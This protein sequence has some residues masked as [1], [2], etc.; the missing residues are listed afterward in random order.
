[1]S[2][3]LLSAEK[4]GA[5][6][7]F[8]SKKTLE[9][10]G[11]TV[12]DGFQLKP[13]Y[14]LTQVRAI[15][16]R[17]NQNYDGWPSDELKKSY[18][19]F[20]GKPCFVNHENHDPT[21][22]RGV[23]VA[24]RY[25][26]SGMDKYIET[27]MEIDAGR[28]PKL[29]H[30][31]K[32]GGLDSV[33]MGAEAGF[34]IC[35]YCHNKATDLHDMCSHVRNHKGKTLSR[36]D[37]KT[38]K[39][40][41]V[42][43]FESCHKISFFEL[44][45]VF[46]PADE[47]AVASKVVVAGKQAVANGASE[48]WGLHHSQDGLIDT[49]RTRA[50]AEAKLQEIADAHERGEAVDNPNFISIVPPSTNKMR[51][52]VEKGWDPES[53]PF[54]PRI[55]GASVHKHAGECPPGM[56]CSRTIPGLE[57]ITKDSPNNP[58]NQVSYDPASLGQPGGGGGA[59]SGYQGNGKS[60]R[61]GLNPG[62]QSFYDQ[63]AKEFPGAS[64]GGYNPVVDQPW[65]EHGTG[66]AFDFMTS[67]INQGNA[68]K[69]RALANGAKHVIWQQK[70]W[71]PG[72]G[73]EAMENRGSPTEN[74]YDH[75]HFNIPTVAK[76]VTP[77]PAP[78]T[79]AQPKA[80]APTTR[81]AGKYTKDD[82]AIADGKKPWERETPKRA[83]VDE[84]AA[85]LKEIEAMVR[86]SAPAK[87]RR[88]NLTDEYLDYMYGE[89][90]GTDYDV[91]KHPMDIMYDEADH[92]RGRSGPRSGPSGPGVPALHHA[93]GRVPRE[94][95]GLVSSWLPL[96]GA[97]TPD[98]R[99]PVFAHYYIPAADN[100]RA[101]LRHHIN[102]PNDP[103][104]DPS[105]PSLPRDEASRLAE[106]P[107][108]W[109]IEQTD[110]VTGKPRV[111]GYTN[112]LHLHNASF[113]IS[114]SGQKLTQTTGKK[115][116]HAGVSGFMIPQPDEPLEYSNVEY[117][118]YAH[119]DFVH[120]ENQQP[121]GD[122]DEWSQRRG[123]RSPST[124]AG[125]RSNGLADHVHLSPDMSMYA[126]RAD[127]FGLE[128]P[129]VV[130]PVHP[131]VNA[132][133][134]DTVIP[135]I[136]P[137]QQ[138]PEVAARTR[139]VMEKRRMLD[140]AK[141]RSVVGMRKIAR[142][143]ALK[144]AYGEVEAPVR[145]DTLREEGSAPEDDN[146][147]DQRYVDPA[148]NDFANIIS[149][150]EELQT[151]DLSEAG[152]ID[153]EQQQDSGQSG[154]PGPAEGGPAP[155][156]QGN[157]ITLKIPVPAQAPQVP[158]QAGPPVAA[159]PQP[160][161][162]PQA[163]AG[164]PPGPQQPPITASLLNYFD[165]YYGRRVA[166]WLDAIEAGRALNPAE[167]ADYRRQTEKFSTLENAGRVSTTDRY[168]R[169]GTANMA[170]TSIANRN[171]V[172][173]AGRR[174]HFAEGPLVDGGDRSRNDQ[175]E[176]EKA[177]ISQTPPEVPVDFPT[178]DAPNISN[179]EHNLVARVQ[180]G[181]AQLLRDAQALA[182]LQR[183]RAFDEAGGPT[184]EVVDPT[185]Q[186]GP[187]G[188]ALTGTGFISADPN[189]GVVPT[190]PKDASLR[191]FRAFDGWLTAKTG[192]SSRRHSEATLKKAAA[193]FS[194][195]A[196]I[197]PQALF[198]ALGIVLREARKNDKQA[199]TKGAKMRKRADEKLEVA[200]PDGRVDVEA[201]VSNTTDAEA[202]ASQFD[203]HDFGNNAGDNVADPDL[204]TDQNWS[205]G[206]ASKTSA[207]VKTAGGLLAMR[208]AEGMI[209]AGLEP[210]SRERKYQLAAEFEQ[211]NRGLIQDRVALL[212]RFAAV[213]QAE[214]R[215]VASGDSR[216]A[217][218]SPIPAGLGGGTRTAAGPSQRTAAHDPSN[219]STLFI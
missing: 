163:P 34:T 110:P 144:L 1:M 97:P 160:A 90:G 55:F 109:S 76:P 217:A 47:T 166:N 38:G 126:N 170:R 150:P 175:G 125:Y 182:S 35:S 7:V 37:R 93:A 8:G 16:A 147:D 153:R 89:Y 208:C 3:R 98:P 86:A 138:H 61:D 79:T 70:L 162:P 219:D 121:V 198:P 73:S 4:T 64:M 95:K 139:E 19:T 149:S 25:A 32:T 173:T 20:I 154:V 85:D 186:T 124:P 134:S 129:K 10:D 53:D 114:R 62:A 69:D 82:F 11:W 169:K 164:P 123:V 65:D 60:G 14:V 193:A 58:V 88:A 218:R 18:R 50:E 212:E 172:A 191:A 2:L 115:G 6:L 167:A 42:L 211:M 106:Q 92:G 99:L 183:R 54:D 159:P 44:S 26:E 111:R 77:A 75:V 206:E 157:F 216:G 148:D 187:E 177:F 133:N 151:P 210:N 141:G 209:E 184:A 33:S 40:E 41:E 145:V 181:R 188:E 156:D 200:A 132:V 207:R 171:K 180:Q 215:K 201:P 52:E 22:A 80:V 155:Q 21:K 72:G 161:M 128:Q 91:P 87:P 165:G 104:H 136:K 49:A 68:L 101:A 117:N 30:E 140:Q 24:A 118:P 36:L 48:Y 120:R 78:T 74:H 103:Q 197:S 174:Q 9:Q 67:D 105:R 185:V 51:E 137:G 31:I 176:Q 196:G 107:N 152:Q 100:Q 57:Q 116:V 202:Q 56:D 28:F 12:L 122:P 81:A 113:D 130:F 17:V 168:P 102:D 199:N 119:M 179:T 39:R 59:S 83:P 158:L 213:R 112:Q 96:R 178:D 195:E 5:S 142:H 71:Y 23:V 84:E 45:F 205:P 194:R 63:L 94:L 27:V 29:A 203:L 127:G 189:D 131:S 146:N 192:K 43:V 108:L 15:S 190:N 204:S 135:G 66:D 214:R 46:E 13:G 143:R